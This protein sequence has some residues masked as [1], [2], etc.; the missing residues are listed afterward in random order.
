MKR[1]LPFLAVAAALVSVTVFAQV[2][3]LKPKQTI[4]GGTPQLQITNPK[5]TP[6]EYQVFEIKDPQPGGIGI[7]GRGIGTPTLDSEGRLVFTPGPTMI[8]VGNAQFQELCNEMG[9]KGW[10][11]IQLSPRVEAGTTKSYRAVFKRETKETT[12]QA[13]RR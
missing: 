9:K 1:L 10:E 2:A 12:V 11:L 6:F 13:I 8:E 4:P 7:G 5:W 3:N